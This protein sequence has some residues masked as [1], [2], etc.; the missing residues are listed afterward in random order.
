[1]P[2]RAPRKKNP[3][4]IINDLRNNE[5]EYLYFDADDD[6]GR[7]LLK[8]NRKNCVW[9]DSTAGPSGLFLR[10][11]R[12][13]KDRLSKAD[14]DK[15]QNDTGT[16]ILSIELIHWASNDTIKFF[17]SP[18]IKRF[19]DQWSRGQ[20]TTRYMF[21][22]TISWNSLF[23][24]EKIDDL[25]QQK[26]KIET[27]GTRT[28][29]S[30]SHNLPLLDGLE[31]I[32]N[33]YR[34]RNRTNDV[35]DDVDDEIQVSGNF[36]AALGILL[37]QSRPEP[38][39]KMPRSET[40]FDTDNS[41]NELNSKSLTNV[42]MNK[43]LQPLPETDDVC[44]V[45]SCNVAEK[46][47]VAMQPN[48]P[49]PA[50]AVFA[51]HAYRAVPLY[52]SRRA[53]R[54]P[55]WELFA[56]AHLLVHEK[57]HAVQCVPVSKSYAVDIAEFSSPLDTL[58]YRAQLFT[59]ESYLTFRVSNCF[60]EAYEY[61][62]IE[63]HPDDPNRFR[64]SSN[65]LAE[66]SAYAIVKC[67]FYKDNLKNASAK[68]ISIEN[69]GELVDWPG[70]VEK[71][72]MM[73]TH[74]PAGLLSSAN[75]RA[76]KE[77]YECVRGGRT[78][79]KAQLLSAFQNNTISN[80]KKDAELSKYF[81]K[82]QYEVNDT[83]TPRARLRRLLLES[84]KNQSGDVL[85]AMLSITA[86]WQP[87][88]WTDHVLDTTGVHWFRVVWITADVAN[89]TLLRLCWMTL[90]QLACVDATD[91]CER[92][93]VNDKAADESTSQQDFGYQSVSKEKNSILFSQE[94]PVKSKTKVYFQAFA[95]FPLPLVPV[96]D[97]N[98]FK[99]SANNK[100]FEKQTK[101]AGLPC[102]Q[103]D[104]GC[105][106]AVAQR[107]LE[108]LRSCVRNWKTT[109]V[110]K[111]TWHWDHI[112]PRCLGGPSEDW[113]KQLLCARCHDAK[114]VIDEWRN[115]RLFMQ[116]WPAT[117]QAGAMM[118]LHL[119]EY[120]ENPGGG[121]FANK[122]GNIALAGVKRWVDRNEDMLNR[123]PRNPN[124]SVFLTL[125]INVVP[126]AVPITFFPDFTLSSADNKAKSAK[127]AAETCWALC[128][129]YFVE[130]L[131][132][133][134]DPG[135]QHTPLAPMR[136]EFAARLEHERESLPQGFD[137]QQNV[138]GAQ[139][140]L[141]TL[142]G[143]GIFAGDSKNETRISE[144]AQP[145]KNKQQPMYRSWPHLR[146]GT[147]ASLAFGGEIRL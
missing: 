134:S 113:N 49:Q 38:K 45:V 129:L 116:P 53:I 89:G 43:R 8:E 106:H 118:F 4:E 52:L 120:L 97:E 102:S 124:G 70:A 63:N 108:K 47:A 80:L 48:S 85:G 100:N 20:Q 109:Q 62:G 84:S 21:Y 13:V 107:P 3:D 77:Y 90:E 65:R 78:S 14:F 94:L 68:T 126:T 112:V 39:S 32:Q 24:V 95:V 142:C 29:S 75:A 88:G 60:E 99:K 125:P 132:S 92:L 73:N 19:V 5:D 131:S 147:N 18:A 44:V 58:T 31:R 123:R 136:F 87:I 30:T 96:M 9:N 27:S 37:P 46:D 144:W 103:H 145:P 128:S 137:A 143:D 93:I 138:E 122:Y 23:A 115:R 119:K 81:S 26:I 76:L 117:L 41:D 104:F 12:S 33:L 11:I 86:T 71:K 98:S 114:T 127:A 74:R 111:T 17:I 6:T 59:K 55:S 35:R 91:V 51:E 40:Q 82:Y 139:S 146:L 101:K 34:F 42:Q 83:N 50:F 64:Y 69:A 66:N 135:R 15:I 28:D 57:A 105:N 54:S 79:P 141:W 10:D 133:P 7:L 2:P 121:T 22:D 72:H 67:T 140:G 130:L 56:V 25:F 16:Q 110:T 1:M 61:R 36:T